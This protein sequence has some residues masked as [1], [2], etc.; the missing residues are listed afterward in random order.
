MLMPDRPVPAVALQM[1]ASR[2]RLPRP[3]RYYRAAMYWI[4]Q[5]RWKRWRVEQTYAK[6]FKELERQKGSRDDFGELNASEHFDLQ[7]IDEM[8]EQTLAIRL[9]REAVSL[10]IELPAWP[11]D[12]IWKSSDDGEFVYLT[13]K[14]RAY[15]RKLIAEEKT[16][17]FEV[18]TLWVTKFWLPLLAAL[19]GIIGALTGLF[20]VLHKK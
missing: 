16:R 11:D 20:A 2:S 15:V 8:I 7:D 13:N 5:L 10:D 1:Q 18:K 3:L 17:R 4:W 12:E 9:R 14:G 6:K 19:I